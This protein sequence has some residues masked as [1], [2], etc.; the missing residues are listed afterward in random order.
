MNMKYLK[1]LAVF[2]LLFSSVQ[3]IAQISE[4]SAYSVPEKYVEKVEDMN[5][6]EI[7][8]Y[9]QFKDGG[10]S[11][12]VAVYLINVGRTHNNLIVAPSTLID[13]SFTN[14]ENGVHPEIVL[15]NMSDG[16]V[17][18]LAKGN[19]LWHPNLWIYTN[20]R[21]AENKTLDKDS[22]GVYMNPEDALASYM[23]R[24][25]MELLWRYRDSANVVILGSSRP[26]NALSPKEFSSPFFAV[27]FA[28]VPNSIYASHDYLERYLLVHL[29][30]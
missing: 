15:V 30:K 20:P 6:S 5:P 1:F 29:K 27:N 26:L 16:S 25:N 17:V 2:A 4:Y 3:S 28:H 22:A 8:I 19:E 10:A 13:Y 23:M 24:N 11:D 7:K 12:S 21:A 14:S 18:E 9:N